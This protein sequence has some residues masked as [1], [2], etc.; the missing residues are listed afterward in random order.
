MKINNLFKIIPEFNRTFSRPENKIGTLI[1]SLN[2]WFYFSSFR[3]SFSF[4]TIVF[5][6]LKLKNPQTETKKK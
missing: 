4:S 6:S 3:P 1:F 2:T 5:F